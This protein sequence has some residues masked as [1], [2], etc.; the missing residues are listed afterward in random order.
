MQAT[1]RRLSVVSATSC[2]RRRL[3]R[4]V[5]LTESRLVST[6]SKLP[7]RLTGKNS[8]KS[9]G[10]HLAPSLAATPEGLVSLKTGRVHSCAGVVFVGKPI[11]PIMILE[12]YRSVSSV[13]IP[14]TE[15]LNRLEA[16]CASMSTQPIGC[17]IEISYDAAG[18]PV[19]HVA[20]RRF[21][22]LPESK[23]P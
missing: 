7:V 2:A 20:R 13:Q 1:A 22:P 10:D 17:L 9:T 23:L 15:A 8:E 16:F 14:D 21:G 11:D 18:S 5:R 4:D 19:I 3:I 6:T 12:R